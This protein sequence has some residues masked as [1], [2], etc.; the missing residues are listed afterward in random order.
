MFRQVVE[1]RIHTKCYEHLIRSHN[2]T[3]KIE[4]N[5]LA[6]GWCY[7]YQVEEDRSHEARPYMS[8]LQPKELLCKFGRSFYVIPYI[9]KL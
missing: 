9:N 2:L 1:R 5:T 4:W 8:F 6:R 3:V 7:I